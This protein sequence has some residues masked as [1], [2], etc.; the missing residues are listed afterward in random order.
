MSLKLDWFKT[1]LMP[2]QH[3][4]KK[5]DPGNQSSVEDVISDLQP[6]QDQYVNLVV[7]NRPDLVQGIDIKEAF[8]IYGSFQLLKKASAWGDIPVQCTCRECFKNCVC[9]HGVLFTSLFDEKLRVPGEYIAA[10]VGLWKKC[11]SLKGAAGT[12]RKRLIAEY[13][14][15]KKK[16]ES[17]IKFMKVP[18]GPKVF[19]PSRFRLA[20][21]QRDLSFPTQIFPPPPKARR[22]FP[23]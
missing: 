22:R 14:A 7:R 16:V 17:K 12:K 23:P 1:V 2:A 3:I 6:L 11:R 9:A 5:L 15:A 8:K 10:T 21:S 13:A 20:R 4:L 18:E 19:G